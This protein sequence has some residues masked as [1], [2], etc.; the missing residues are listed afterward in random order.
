MLQSARQL[1]WDNP[2]D[3]TNRIFQGIGLLASKLKIDPADISAYFDIDGSTLTDPADAERAATLK[4]LGLKDASR[5]GINAGAL[6]YI[7]KNK[8]Q[9]L[10]DNNGIVRV[11]DDNFEQVPVHAYLQ[12][13]PRASDQGTGFFINQ[14]GQYLYIPKIEEFADW[15]NQDFGPLVSSAIE[16]RRLQR[17]YK[18]IGTYDPYHSY[19]SNTNPEDTS[20][21]QLLDKVSE[22]I[23]SSDFKFI[24]MSGYFRGNE[25]TIGVPMQ[26]QIQKDYLGNIQFDPNMPVYKL[27]ANGNLIPTTFQQASLEGYYYSGYGDENMAQYKTYDLLSNVE[28]NLNSPDIVNF[29]FGDNMWGINGWERMWNGYGKNGKISRNFHCTSHTI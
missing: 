8:W 17:D 21:Q 7:D 16:A 1:D 18:N 5:L 2:S 14:N 19:V 6:A 24:D 20:M 25:A 9:L 15:N 26:G 12:D 11:Y 27:D 10:Q 3:E 4:Q 23:G 22:R 29:N 28:E 13:D